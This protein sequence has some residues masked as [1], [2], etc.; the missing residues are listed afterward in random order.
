[1][2]QKCL[3][4]FPNMYVVDVYWMDFWSDKWKTTHY[5]NDQKSQKIQKK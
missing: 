2:V 3:Q 4:F 5:Q 1:M